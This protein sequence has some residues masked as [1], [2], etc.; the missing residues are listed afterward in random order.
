MLYRSFFVRAEVTKGPNIERLQLFVLALRTQHSGSP[1]GWPRTRQ[2]LWPVG[3]PK[4]RQRHQGSIL[5]QYVRFLRL[6][7]IRSRVMRV[8]I[9]GSVLVHVNSGQSCDRKWQSIGAGLN[10]VVYVNRSNV[11]QRRSERL[12]RRDQVVAPAEHE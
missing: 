5:R 9:I 3:N 12:K 7:R 10:L 8:L 2:P 6:Q 1:L 4:R 11:R